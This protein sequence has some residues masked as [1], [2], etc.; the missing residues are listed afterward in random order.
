MKRH[1]LDPTALV[2][3][4]VFVLIAAGRLA[5]LSTLGVQLQY[6]VPLGLIGA[7]TAIVL[8]GRR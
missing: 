1:P 2:A 8:G 4:V 7:G 6:V 5:G 3:G